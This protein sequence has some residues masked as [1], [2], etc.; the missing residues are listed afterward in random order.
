MGQRRARAG[1]REAR[2]DSAPA[3]RP[4]LSAMGCQS[5]LVPARHARDSAPCAQWRV[6]GTGRPSGDGMSRLHSLALLSLLA[7]LLVGA[8]I[9][10]P[11]DAPTLRDRYAE[12]WGLGK[13][14]EAVLLVDG[15]HLPAA[16][17]RH[18]MFTP[19][20]CAPASTALS[21]VELTV[22]LPVALAVVECIAVDE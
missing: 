6:S 1:V 12:S 16:V 5:G 18:Q 19:A 9:W 7:G 11:A 14:G 15:V 4:V 20:V 17:G 3:S 22:R 2:R 10:L 8:G 13:S 21:N